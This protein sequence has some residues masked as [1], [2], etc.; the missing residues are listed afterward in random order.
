M[1][2]LALGLAFTRASLVWGAAV[3]WARIYPSLH[4]PIDMAGAQPRRSW[5]P[6]G[7][8]ASPPDRA[9]GLAARRVD[10]ALGRKRDTVP[11]PPNASEFRRQF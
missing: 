11:K 4:F 6:L 9:L 1:W 3:A 5:E 8:T 2:S 7:R 10:P